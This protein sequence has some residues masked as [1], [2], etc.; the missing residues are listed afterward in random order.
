MAYHFPLVIRVT[1]TYEYT[2]KGNQWPNMPS[3]DSN[4]D[5]Q[6]LDFYRIDPSFSGC[7]V[8]V[9]VGDG[10]Q[11][12]WR[13]PQS[14]LFLRFIS[15][16]VFFKT[17][18]DKL[19]I[20][21]TAAV[22]HYCAQSNKVSIQTFNEI[23]LTNYDDV[24]NYISWFLEFLEQKWATL[25]TRGPFRAFICVL[26]ARFKSEMTIQNLKNR[27]SWAGCGPWA[28]YCPFLFLRF[29]FDIITYY[30]T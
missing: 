23:E 29:K 10:M 4:C 5:V 6:M 26:R 3:P 12:G 14:C 28:V 22:L 25:L 21:Q 13:R 2:F 27:P 18:P 8:I 11:R 19:G 20:S 9:H 7:I 30:K 15:F 16:S 1:K 17:L 24:Q